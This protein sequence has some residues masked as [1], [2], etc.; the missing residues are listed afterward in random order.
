MSTRFAVS[1][2][3][4]TALSILDDAPVPSEELAQSASTSAA[5]VRQL[6]SRL[7][8]AGLVTSKL[9]PGGGSMLSRPPEQI[10]LKEVY[11]AVE[12][13]PIFCTHREDPSEACE[14]GKH[15]LEVLDEPMS[16]AKQ[17]MLNSLASYT[18]ADIARA[19]EARCARTGEGCPGAV[20]Q[21]ERAS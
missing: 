13:T 15:I 17:A 21:R 11:E 3:L 19:I 6:L 7:S 1:T 18:I 8:G 20:A 12:T 16:A 10:T 2:H 14:V 9:G 4:L 5:V